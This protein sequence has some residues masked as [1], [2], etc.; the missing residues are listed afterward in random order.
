M[1]RKLVEA[2]EREIVILQKQVESEERDKE[3]KEM[4]QQANDRLAI[5][6]RSV[7]A[8][9]VQNYELHEYPIPRLFVILER[10]R[11]TTPEGHVKL[12]CLEY[13]RTS[14][15]KN[16]MRS[17]LN[18][19]YVNRGLYDMQLRKIIMTL[20]SS[21]LVKDFMKQLTTYPF[22]ADELDLTM[23]FEFNTADLKEIV[24]NLA[25]SNVRILKLD[26]DDKSYRGGEANLLSKGKYHPLFE[27]LS[28]RKLQQLTL[29]GMSNFGSRASD[30]SKDQKLS[31]LRS[32]HFHLKDNSDI[33]RCLSILPFCANLV[34]LRLVANG[35]S[36]KQ[37]GLGSAIRTL[38]RLEVLHIIGMRLFHEESQERLP[39]E[40]VAA[41]TNLRELVVYSGHP[42][43]DE[44]RDVTLLRMSNFGSRISDLSKNQK[45]ST[46]QSVYFHSEDNSDIPRLLSI[47][48]FCTNL[49]D[50]RLVTN[51]CHEYKSELGRAISALKRLEVLHLIGSPSEM[52][53]IMHRRNSPIYGQPQECPMSVI[54]ATDI[55]LRELVVKDVYLS[56]D[57]AIDEVVHACRSTLEVLIYDGKV[58][59][60]SPRFKYEHCFPKLTC[61]EVILGTE[62]A[63]QLVE[64]T[65]KH[66]L[67]HLGIIEDRRILLG[68]TNFTALHSLAIRNVEACD[69]LPLWKS[70]PENG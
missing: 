32:F 45:Q 39:S 42:F 46:L 41:D 56:R 31:T 53:L 51:N 68:I 15:R 5:L 65:L 17:L 26:L 36:R 52:P 9:L 8:I 69:L 61:L 48:S 28:N 23:D 11:V 70:F 33:S 34:E 18:T 60:P 50:L 14:Y 24:R 19:I 20:P 30:L 44:A 16:A 66:R 49:I 2:R 63:L 55:K 22:A 7:D 12:V 3:H 10:N 6:Q 58:D 47:L 29:T 62:S 1:L 4:L 37:P 64:S 57:R 38:K 21:I 40:I 54:V 67:S 13:F 27:L 25:K 59:L 35:S 43:R